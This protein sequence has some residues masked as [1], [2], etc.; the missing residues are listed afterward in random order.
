L[1]RIKPEK[2]KDW[3]E[4]MVRKYD[5][6]AFH[7]HPNLFIRFVERKRVKA[8][9][10]MMRIHKED[11]VLEVG[12]GA[13][14]VIEKASRGKLFGLDISLYIL[15]KAKEKLNQKI[16]LLQ[17]DAQYLPFKDQV[18]RQIICS[19]VLEHLLDPS[20]GLL[21]MVR[22]LKTEGAVIVSI[23]NE[24]LIN[25]IKGIL[26]R[27][28]IFQRL[29]QCKGDYG[30]MPKRMEDEWHLHTFK[31]GGWLDLFRKYFRVTRLKRIPFGG[32]PLRY[33]IRLEKMK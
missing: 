4:R 24:S 17:A 15:S 21:E 19:E 12:C 20:A 23:P 26:I 22:V 32:L 2:F 30:E 25:Q 5:P 18:F 8:I 31:L 7:H 14:N 29:F 28:G 27:L 3:N 33:V 11:Y 10:K 13:G 16:Y 6:N 9:F 1:N